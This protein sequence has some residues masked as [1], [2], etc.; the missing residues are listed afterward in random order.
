MAFPRKAVLLLLCICLGG[1][2]TAWADASRQ[3]SRVPQSNQASLSTTPSLSVI[4]PAPDFTLLDTAGQSVSLSALRGNVVLLSFI[5]TSCPSACPLLTARMSLLWKRLSR[6]GADAQRVRFVSITVDP[7]RDS[8][9]VLQEYANR[10]KVDTA[11]W[12][13]LREEP[14]KLG[15]ALAAY[16]EWT[17]PQPDG[18]IDHPARLYLIDSQGRIREIYSIS[19]FDE[20][21]VFF[22]I[23]ALLSESQ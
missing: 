7:A 8:A 12:K 3:D 23:Q 14:Q 17:R 13:F 4:K 9:G 16:D 6:D 21:Q 18:E 20:R 5:Y 22:D 2:L 1:S 11:T 19:F 10:F 15:P